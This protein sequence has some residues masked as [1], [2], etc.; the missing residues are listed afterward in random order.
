MKDRKIWCSLWTTNALLILVMAGELLH[1]LIGWEIWKHR[2]DCVF[3]NA[4]LSVSL[5]VRMV[6]E[7]DALRCFWLG[8]LGPFISFSL[9]VILLSFSGGA[10]LPSPL[11]LFFSLNEMTCSSPVSYKK[12]NVIVCFVWSLCVCFLW[13]SALGCC[14]VS[15]CCTFCTHFLNEMTA[16]LLHSSRKENYCT[17]TI[18]T[19]N[20]RVMYLYF[21]KS[22]FRTHK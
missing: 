4:V 17:L 5:I 7:E 3:N 11:Y 6:E 2:N 13:S 9:L 1:I 18:C 19:L 14:L 12:K 10:V 16:S 21:I 15:W 20:W 22:S 8:C